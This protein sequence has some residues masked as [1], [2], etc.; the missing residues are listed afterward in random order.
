M[1]KPTL[2]QELAQLRVEHARLLAE[3]E[4]ANTLRLKVSEKGAVS[5]YGLSRFPFTVYREQWVK[6][7]EF[8]DVILKFIEENDASLKK[9]G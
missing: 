2:E 6:I 5:L 1:A 4:K 8:K 3:K 7:L 9:K